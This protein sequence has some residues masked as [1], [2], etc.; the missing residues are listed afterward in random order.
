[1]A[2]YIDIIKPPMCPLILR[3]MQH[4]TILTPNVTRVCTYLPEVVVMVAAPVVVTSTAV[5][6][7]STAFVVVTSAAERGSKTECET[8]CSEEYNIKN[9]VN[10]CVGRVN[11]RESINNISLGAEVMNNV[12]EVVP[13][14]QG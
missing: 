7:T 13:C 12:G 10:Y 5:V 8:K 9:C 14:V 2:D 11:P 1:M 6:V 3:V 4:L